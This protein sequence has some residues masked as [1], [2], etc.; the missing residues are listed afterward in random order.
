MWLRRL[1][2]PDGAV[3]V[4]ASAPYAGV[5]VVTA[6]AI[7]DGLADEVAKKAER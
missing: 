3:L 6:A 4:S 2:G 1:V 5:V 7:L